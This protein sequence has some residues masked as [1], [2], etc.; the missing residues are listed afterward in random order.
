MTNA[1]I[2]HTHRRW[3]AALLVLLTL[4]LHIIVIAWGKTQLTNIGATRH[5]DKVVNVTLREIARPTEPVKLPVLASSSSQKPAQKTRPPAPEISDS[6]SRLSINEDAATLSDNQIA[7]DHEAS[8]AGETISS[9]TTDVE[10]QTPAAQ[11]VTYQVAPPPS[12]AVSYD[13]QAIQGTLTYR[14]MGTITWKTDG[15]AYTIRGEATSLF[16]TLLGFNSAGTI[17]AYG[18]SPSLYTE[19][20]F[21]KPVTSTYFGGETSEIRFSGSDASY[22]IVGGEQDRASLVWQLASIGRGDASQIYTGAVIDL[23]VAGVRDGEV[24][25]VQVI[26]QERLSTAIGHLDTWH[27]VRQP[28][29]GAHDQRIDIWFAPDNQWYP[30]KLRYTE[31]NDDYLDMS[32]TSV[33]LLQ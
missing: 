10:G 8:D 22:P 20:R 28:K 33:K 1:A 16:M 12:V 27:V 17:N 29:P 32:V 31:P 15:Q 11:G 6:S 24:W 13:V 14:A 9:S 5:Q 18:V 30:V 25:R 7:D 23:F 3:R 26:G 2:T 21:R 4:C 19:E